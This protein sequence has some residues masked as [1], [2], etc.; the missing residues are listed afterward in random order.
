MSVSK[1]CG[2][3]YG[4][5]GDSMLTLE[6]KVSCALCGKLCGKA[7]SVEESC[8]ESKLI[9]IA[10][11]KGNSDSGDGL[12]GSTLVRKASDKLVFV[13]VKTGSL[14]LFGDA[15]TLFAA[16]S[17]DELVTV[18]ECYHCEGTFCGTAAAVKL[19]GLK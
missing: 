14:F 16:V 12:F 13:F 5:R 7:K 6:V 2:I 1:L 10:E 8:P 9:V 11:N 3:A 18:G 17:A 15:R 4:V 19:T